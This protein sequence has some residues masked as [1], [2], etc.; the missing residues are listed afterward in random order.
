MIRA[1]L[2][3]NL[4]VSYLL[5]NGDTLS[6]IMAHWEAGRFVSL[7]SPQMLAELIDVLNRPRLRP[8]LKADPQVLINLIET[9]AEFVNGELALPG[10]CRDPKDDKFIACAVEGNASYIVTG[11]KDLL[12]LGVYQMVKVV[13]AWDFLTLLDKSQ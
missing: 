13:R 7:Q 8:Y 4:L 10:A 11:D 2:D 12:D 1:V 6:R 5:T 9:D 3:T